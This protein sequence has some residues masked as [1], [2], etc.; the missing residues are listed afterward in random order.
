MSG[1]LLLLY[2]L[3]ALG[4]KILGDIRV[5]SRLKRFPKA[6][7]GSYA[8][9]GRGTYCTVLGIVAVRP[10][11]GR[12]KKKPKKLRRSRYAFSITNLA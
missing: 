4:S 11:K 12:R 5:A 7:G 10:K 3:A 6:L 8:S 9:R 1:R 2:A